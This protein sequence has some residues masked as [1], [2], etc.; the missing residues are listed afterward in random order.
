MT[1]TGHQVVYVP[2]YKCLVWTGVKHG[3]LVNTTQWATHHPA[4]ALGQASYE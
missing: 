1:K 2:A 3:I 4:Q